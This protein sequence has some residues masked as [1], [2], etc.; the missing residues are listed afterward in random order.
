[1][2]PLLALGI[3]GGNAAAIMLMALAIKGVNMGPL[4]LVSQPIYMYTTF[5][6]MFVVNIIMVVIAYYVAKGFAKILEIPYSMLGTIILM[7]CFLG[8]F[9]A[10]R[11]IS[12]VL[13]VVIA[14]IVG[15][16]LS[17]AKFNMAGLIGRCWAPLWKRTCA[18]PL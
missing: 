9:S 10:S 7:L 14:G 2:V 11:N 6:S 5:A 8:A 3:P 16:G 13:L 1:M 4:L 17:K 18:M 12:D 15:Y